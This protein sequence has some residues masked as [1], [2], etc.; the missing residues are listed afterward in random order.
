MDMY[1]NMSKE[2]MIDENTR[3]LGCFI[4]SVY[5]NIIRIFGYSSR[6]QKDKQAYI[7]VLQTRM[8]AKKG[9]LTDDFL[10]PLNLTNEDLKGGLKLPIN[11][12]S[13]ALRATFNA[14]Y[15]NL[16]GFSICTTGQLL[17]L[18]LAYDLQQVSTLEIISCNTDAIMYMIDDE[19]KEQAHKVLHDWEDLT[20][21]ELEEDKVVKICMRDVNNYCEIVQVGD[22]D[23][24]VNYKG[25]E[26]TRGEHKFKWNKE[27]KKFEYT[28]KDSLKSNSMTIVSEALLKKLL[29]DI[30]I[31]TTINNCN[32]IFRFQIISHLGSTYEKCVQETPNGDIELQKN[33]RIYAGLQPSGNIIKVKPD[34]RR[35]SLANCPPNPIV[36]NGNECTIDMI[37]KEWYIE[38]TTEKYTKFVGGRLLEEYKK[39]ELLELCTENGILVDKRTKKDKLIKIIKNYKKGLTNNIQ[40]DNIDNVKGDNE[41]MATKQELEEKLEKAVQQNEQLVAKMK[42]MNKGDNGMNNDYKSLYAKINEFRKEIRKIKFFYDSEL[43]GN[44]G[45]GEYYSIDQFYDAV[46]ETSLKVGLDFSFET[47]SIDSFEKELFK[48]AGKPPIHVVTIKALAMLTDIDTGLSKTY[49]IM[50]QGSDTMDKA[51]SGAMTSAFRQWFS[52]NFTPKD[53]KESESD[54]QA[55]FDSQKSETPK[56]PVFI[57]EQKK[58]E[59]KKEVV[60]QVQKDENMDNALINSITSNVMKVRDLL[61]DSEYGKALIDDIVAGKLN[62]IELQAVSLQIESKL[63]KLES[64]N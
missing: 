26:L 16:Q 19:Y 46:Q 51:V 39:D 17:L 3:K 55:V 48:P 15:D 12:Y 50:G 38:F 20:G 35:D 41:N 25:G 56:V 59:I 42:E 1:G 31:E 53:F 62:T 23:Y 8:K 14:L 4:T 40:Y 13:G 34:G 43:P 44:L 47:K 24:A 27:K 2:V 10:K 63:E 60:A 54:K 61:N 5:P 36:D 33:N 11:A 45:G 32:D 52:K 58:E 49:D 21:L 7:D 22:N 9:L 29:F 64:V 37:N 28:F 57:P 6:N 18:Q 30:P